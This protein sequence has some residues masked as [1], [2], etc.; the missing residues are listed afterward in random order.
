MHRP[1]TRRLTTLGLALALSGHTSW[2]RPLSQPAARACPPELNRMNAALVNNAQVRAE[3]IAVSFGAPKGEC[4]MVEEAQISLTAE[5]QR[6][7]HDF[8]IPDGQC[9]C[10]TAH[11]PVPARPTPT[12]TPAMEL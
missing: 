5:V 1:L 8:G 12:S 4:F 3:C 10:P 6:L 7:C 2:A 9:G 11:E